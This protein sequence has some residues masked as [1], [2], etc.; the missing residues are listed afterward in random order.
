MY[1]LK[2]KDTTGI[3]HNLDLIPGEEPAMTYQVNDIAELKDRQ[4]DYS[5]QMKLPKTST[6][7]S[8]LERLDIFEANAL[9]PY[10]T[11]ECRL[12]SNGFTLA[13]K[14]SLFVID[15]VGEYIEGQI[16]SGNAGLFSLM[17]NSLMEDADLGYT[18]VG[19]VVMPQWVRRRWAVLGKQFETYKSFSHYFFN[20]H[21]TAKRLVELCGYTLD[22]NLPLTTIQRDFFSAPTLKPKGDSLLVFNTSTDLDKVQTFNRASSP[23]SY[24]PLQIGNNG[25]GVLILTGGASNSWRGDYTSNINGRIKIFVWLGG[26]CTSSVAAGDFPLLM[27]YKFIANKGL[28]NIINYSTVFTQA[29]TENFHF[30][31]IIEVDVNVGDKIY[32]RSLVQ[33]PA[34]LSNSSRYLNL[35]GRF[36]TELIAA[37]EVPIGGKLYF[38]NNTGFTTYLDLFKAFCQS[39]GLTIQV[40]NN[41]KIVKAY[42]MDKLY[43]NKAI[44]KDWSDKLSKEGQELSYVIDGYGQNNFIQFEKKEDLEDKGNFY[45]IN[46]NLEK[47]KE[48]FRIKWESGIDVKSGTYELA[49]IPLYEYD[50]EIADKKKFVK[51]KPHLV[52]FNQVNYNPYFIMTHIPAQSLVDTYYYKLTNRML[53]NAKCLSVEMLLTERDIEELDFFTPIYLKQFG[54]YFYVSKINNFV[55]YDRLTKVDLIRL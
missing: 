11:I 49:Y 41:N 5:R 10:R 36:T 46:E 21:E 6:N 54:A 45:V 34:T 16:I 2:V 12:Y 23:N 24:L 27:T 30:D 32:F 43:E 31:T 53:V 3:W 51:S 13:G 20:L 55:A 19:S 39:Y 40:D 25:G 14:G 9:T 28:E 18:I 29:T 15:R 35:S 37:D 50:E 33:V 17:Q 1:E 26:S 7:L 4:A 52:K 22:T 44:A 48:L 8:I 42:T 47:E 38:G